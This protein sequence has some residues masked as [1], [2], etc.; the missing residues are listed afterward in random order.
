MPIHHGLA[1]WVEALGVIAAI[2]GAAWIARWQD[3]KTHQREREQQTKRAK[4]VAACFVPILKIIE[5]DVKEITRAYRSQHRMKVQELGQYRF[6]ELPSSVSFVLENAHLL[7]GDAIISTPQLLSL[8]ELAANNIEVC[9]ARR[10]PDEVLSDEELNIITQWLGMMQ[11]LVG[12]NY[13]LL[14]KIHDESIKTLLKQ[15][16]G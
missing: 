6:H 10:R 7:P 12:E 3:R 9:L 15:S 5:Y 11:T 13:D 4:S 14:Q 8:R 1:S 16:I 2:F